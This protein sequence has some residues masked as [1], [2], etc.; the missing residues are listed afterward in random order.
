M[1]EP[2]DVIFRAANIEI[3]EMVDCD[4]RRH[5]EVK[6]RLEKVKTAKSYKDIPPKLWG[7]KSLSLKDTLPSIIDG[8]KNKNYSPDVK[9]EIDLLIYDNRIQINIVGKSS[10]IVPKSKEFEVWRSVSMV[11]NNGRACVFY[12]SE[13]APD[14]IKKKTGEFLKI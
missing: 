11:M 12:A 6:E 2:P 1:N 9:R 3:M 14:F 7:I 10:E 5:Q 8:L 13:D 4:R